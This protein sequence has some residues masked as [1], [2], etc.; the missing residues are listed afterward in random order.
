MAG[1]SNITVRILGDASNFKRSTKQAES[2]VR[3]FNGA[4]KR[5]AGGFAALEVLRFGK[6]VVE[7]AAADEEAQAVLANA[8]KNKTGATE[9]DIAATEEWI[10]AQSLALGVADDELRPALAL[11][12]GATGD[13]I[14]AQELLVEAQDIAAGSGKDLES[15][16]KDLAKLQNGNIAVLKKYGISTKDA[17]GKTLTLAAAQK[18]LN[19]QFSGA[20]TARMDTAAGKWDKLQ[21]QFD[22][23]K[24][25]LGGALLP[26]LV[27]VGEW[28]GEHLPG[29]VE[30]AKS[31]LGD[32]KAFIQ[33]AVDAVKDFLDSE[34]WN[35]VKAAAAATLD[36]IGDKLQSVTNKIS[37]LFNIANI[38]FD[39]FR[40]DLL[41]VVKVLADDFF[42][43]TQGIRNNKLA[44]DVLW[45][46]VAALL[47]A[48][49]ALKVVAM[50]TS[51]FHALAA[52][53][54][55]A[56]IGMH[57]L[58]VAFRANPIGLVVGGLVLLVSLFKAAYDNVGWFRSGVEVLL[59]VVKN[60]AG[61]IYES[62]KF[63]FNGIASLW[64]NT[65]GKIEFKIPS[66]VPGIGGV[67]FA[68]PDIPIIGGSNPV[69]HTKDREGLARFH[70]GG[71]FRS[72]RA[73]GEGLALL[74]DGERV[75]TPGD[76]SGRAAG[77]P[78]VPVVNV[79]VAGHV[80]A[81]RDL[82]KVI[83]NELIGLGRRGYVVA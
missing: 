34:L 80:R 24:E 19:D 14:E 12:A 46:A 62:F 45:G 52:A 42:V 82:A 20:N 65:I 79:Y 36:E 57:G 26:V 16:A 76:Q 6:D 55:T 25:S 7:A 73:G 5:L 13:L 63:A 60:A 56:T 27:A 61:G 35:S 48:F 58:S 66:W 77:Y 32:L 18:K 50:L 54:V 71:L 41:P 68:V 4:L 33:P 69:R 39:F 31:A 72:V 74:R 81:D 53:M 11:L 51:L 47:S 78:A 21:V 44:M 40:D 15:V 28:L 67:K 43:L 2:S 3:S 83:K 30:T 49:T 64:N 37:P 75:L 29:F 10:A 17:S 1:A 38:L 22:E 9:A 70:G 59:K 23:V 8:L